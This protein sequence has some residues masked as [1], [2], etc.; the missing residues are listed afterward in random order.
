MKY[1]PIPFINMKIIKLDFVVVCR[2]AEKTC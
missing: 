1:K 2:E